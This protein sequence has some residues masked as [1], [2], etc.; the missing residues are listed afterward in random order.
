LFHFHKE[1]EIVAHLVRSS[2]IRSTKNSISE[3]DVRFGNAR[4]VGRYFFL[5]L[6]VLTYKYLSLFCRLIRIQ[7]IILKVNKSFTVTLSRT[8]VS[9]SG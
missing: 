7:T 6:A 2:L 8:D 1:R 4:V 9:A 3:K 5:Q